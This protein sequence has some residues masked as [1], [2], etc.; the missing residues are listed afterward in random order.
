M[1][2]SLDFDSKIFDKHVIEVADGKESVVKGGRDLF[3][4]VHQTFKDVEQ[5]GVIGWGS[6]GPAQAQNLRD[7]L[8]GSDTRVKVG[9]R[10]GSA[11]VDEARAAGF[12]EDDNTLGEMLEVVGE[13]DIVILLI[14]DA[15][16]TELYP[17][18]F[19]AIKPGATLGLSHGFLLGY[20]DSV[21]EPFPDNINVIAV[22]PKGMGPSV[23][24]LYVQG[25]EVNGAGINSSFAIHQDVNGKATDYAIAWAVALGS[26]YC[27]QTTLESEYRSDIFGERGI[28]LGAVHG[29]VEA[30]YQRYKGE[31]MTAEDAFNNTAESVTGPISRI[32]SRDGIQAVYDKLEGDDKSRFEAAYVASYTPAREILQEIYDD[33]A[34]GNEIRSVVNASKRFGE[35]PIGEIDG[36]EMWEV[37][38][39]VRANRKEDEIPLH[40]TTAGIYCATMM[41]QIDV[42]LDAG[43]PY[44][45]I[46]NESVI[47]CVDSLNPYMHFKGISF[48]IDNCSTTARLGARK[49]APR[50]D[51]I[52]KQQAFTALDGN[53]PMEWQLIEDFKSHP[54][55]EVLKVVGEMRPSVDISLG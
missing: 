54:I 35:F 49:W 19:K 51:Y 3:P 21:G 8:E 47:E 23:R 30:L 29:I 44:S 14:S 42:L 10:K 5:I 12:T 45:E 43:H 41:A 18:I 4:L 39:S 11:S 6:Q 32:I 2:M 38:K 22:C 16:Q 55:H 52:L 27:F 25:K 31:G 1:V 17:D 9:L 20:L 36:T 24:R 46:V 26:P 53:V 50:F 34:C 40:P 33:V 7:T 13:S 37:G 28:L 48:M 15:A